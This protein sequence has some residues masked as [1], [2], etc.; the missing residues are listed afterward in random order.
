MT[1]LLPSFEFTSLI[2]SDEQGAVFLANQRSLDRQV[3]SKV[4]A[5]HF[6]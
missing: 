3:A 5:P 1:A 2:A 4:L 6:S